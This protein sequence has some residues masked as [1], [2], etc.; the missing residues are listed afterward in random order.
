[1]AR[2]LEVRHEV[3][4]VGDV[5]GRAESA[6]R[7]RNDGGGGRADKRWRGKGGGGDEKE[8]ERDRPTDETPHFAD[9]SAKSGSNAT[10]Q[11]KLRA[12]SQQIALSVVTEFTRVSLT[13][14]R[15]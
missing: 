5:A 15:S 13:K 14:R 12:R 1:V 8:K 3:R 2:H 9:L 11:S 10:A 6:Q 4:L 7:R